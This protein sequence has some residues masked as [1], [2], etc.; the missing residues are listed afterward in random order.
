MSPTTLG[1]VIVDG[2][3]AIAFGAAELGSTRM[4]DAY[5]DLFGFVIELHVSNGPRRRK[6]ENVLVKFF[7]LQ[8]G[9]PRWRILQNP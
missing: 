8:G 3:V 1:S 5:A 9:S 6:P 2:A 7:V 4:L